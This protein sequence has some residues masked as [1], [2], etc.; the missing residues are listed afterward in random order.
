MSL[1]VKIEAASITTT[2]IS[3][4][5][6]ACTT[7][8]TFMFSFSDCW[9]RNWIW[10]YNVQTKALFY[11]TRGGLTLAERVIFENWS[12]ATLERDRVTIPLVFDCTG[13]HK[14][15]LQNEE[16]RAKWLENHKITPTHTNQLLWTWTISILVNWNI[17]VSS[18]S[19]QLKK[20]GTESRQVWL[21]N[22]LSRAPH[23][24]SVY[25]IWW[26]R[27]LMSQSHWFPASVT[28]LHFEAYYDGILAK[29]WP[30]SNGL[31]H[32][33]ETAVDGPMPIPKPR[34]LCSL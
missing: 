16:V 1:Q 28:E 29:N 2:S 12:G 25:Y 24:S 31:V 15:N 30:L 13:T 18:N 9:M 3:R 17:T 14:W 7:T 6:Y 4:S 26:S 21:K 34:R 10:W 20:V 11:R 27:F 33:F 23:G 8:H 5:I 22:N 32:G 19:F